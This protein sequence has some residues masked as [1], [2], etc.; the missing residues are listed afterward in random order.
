MLLFE[1]Y[2]RLNVSK[3]RIIRVRSCAMLLVLRSLYR[4][5]YAICNHTH[6]YLLGFSAGVA[7]KRIYSNYK[8]KV[9][10][11][12][13]GYKTI[14]V[15]YF[16]TKIITTCNISIPYCNNIYILYMIFDKPINNHILFYTRHAPSRRDKKTNRV[17]AEKLYETRGILNIYIYRSTEPTDH[18]P[19]K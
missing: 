17:H 10:Q 15:V 8:N 5:K 18:V 3:S 6:K 1:Y 16:V 4:L 12:I 2:I 7:D 19:N 14:I 13:H 11:P 9:H